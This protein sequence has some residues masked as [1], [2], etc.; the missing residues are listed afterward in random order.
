MIGFRL[1]GLSEQGEKFIG[2]LKRVMNP[3]ISVNIISEV[4]L[5][6]EFLYIDRNM[7]SV[8]K[9]NDLISFLEH[10]AKLLKVVVDRDSDYKIVVLTRKD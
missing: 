10:L 6:V 2:N 8:V 9:E 3:K 1:E 7:Q 5:I 4:P